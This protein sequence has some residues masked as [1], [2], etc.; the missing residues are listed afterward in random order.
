MTDVE[1]WV[2]SWESLGKSLWGF[3]S[4]GRFAESPF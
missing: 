3:W 4:L 1:M 2:S